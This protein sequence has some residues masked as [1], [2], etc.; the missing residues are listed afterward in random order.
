MQT[1]G[2][3]KWK[4]T[5]VPVVDPP[6]TNHCMVALEQAMKGSPIDVFWFQDRWKIYMTQKL[7]IQDWFGSAEHCG[8][9]SCRGLF[10][11]VDAAKNWRPPEKWLHPDAVYEVMM[12]ADKTVPSWLPSSTRVHMIGANMDAKKL[13]KTLSDID[14]LEVLPLDFV[15]T[16]HASKALHKACRNQIVEFL[17]LP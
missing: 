8:R 1:L 7:T 11:L 15:L 9:K 14:A 3:G 12:E 17:Y 13:E 4:T 6:T 16:N 5:F 10:W 2:A